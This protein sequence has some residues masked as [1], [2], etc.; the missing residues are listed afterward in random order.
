VQALQDSLTFNGFSINITGNF[1]SD[2]ATQLAKFKTSRR[3]NTSSPFVDFETWH[4]LTSGCHSSKS[5]AFWI[6]VGWPQ[7]S[8]TDKQLQC[9]HSAGFKF[10]TF[11]CWLE[12]NGGTFWQPCIDNIFRAQAA[13]FAVG[14]YMF[15]WRA[16]DASS[17]VSQ[18]L[19]NL[20]V[21]LLNFSHF[22]IPTTFCARLRDAGNQAARVQGIKQVML[23]IEGPTWNFSQSENRDY[24]LALRSTVERGGLNVTVYCTNWPETFGPDFT[25]FKDVPLIYAV[26]SRSFF[27]F[28]DDNPCV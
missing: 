14:I 4:L 28:C 26:P 11:E 20:S 22:Y 18:L 3:M 9:L 2:T 10:I 8:V 21:R 6:D 27:F 15:P 7:G 5:A 25:A 13:G 17:Q 1:D 24:V 23:D 12:R 16:A 19:G